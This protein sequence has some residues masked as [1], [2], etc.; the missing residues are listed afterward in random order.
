MRNVV[1]IRREEHSP[2]RPPSL[3]WF[4]STKD[5]ELIDT[6]VA[7]HLLVS[8]LAQPV[9]LEF[10]GCENISSFVGSVFIFFCQLVERSRATIALFG[11]ITR[12]HIMV[13][14]QLNIKLRGR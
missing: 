9:A 12:R 14:K 8:D 2:T 1:S 4:S 10:G 13:L 5:S 6:E 3:I 11:G 7:I